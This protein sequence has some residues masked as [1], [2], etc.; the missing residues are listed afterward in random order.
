L[1]TF[2]TNGFVV[3]ER[4]S[5][6]SFGDIYYNIFVRDLPVFI[7]TDSILPGSGPSPGSWR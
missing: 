6:K 1:A 7:T 5:D 3:S 4:L 2:R